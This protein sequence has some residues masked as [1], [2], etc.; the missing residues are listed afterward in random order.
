MAALAST[1][2]SAQG[3]EAPTPGNAALVTL[4]R[5]DLTDGANPRAGLVQA[6]NGNFYGTTRAGGASGYGTV[7]EITPSDELTTL[8][9]FDGTDGG[10]PF[11]GLVQAS[12]GRLYGT[13]Y[14]GGANDGGTIFEITPGGA[15]TTLYSFCHQTGCP[16]GA[17]PAAG[18]VQAKNGDL[19]GTAAAGG[20]TNQGTVF[21]IT[22][23][24]ALTE[25]YSF[26][27]QRDCPDGAKPYAALIQASDGNFYGTTSY[28][29]SSGAGTVFRITPGGALTTLHSFCSQI[30]C[31]DGLYPFAGLIQA[32]D[33]NLYGTTSGEGDDSLHGTVFKITPSGTLTTLYSFAPIMAAR[34]AHTRLPGSSRRVTAISMGPQV[35][36]ERL[37]TARYS[38]SPRTAH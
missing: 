22:P 23:S 6:S 3:P 16:D 10:Q 37:A 25:L 34:T 20:A 8:F 19:Y 38:E 29:G 17:I 13:T 7:F 35:M 27:H 14:V 26:C 18:L 1:P 33:G 4:Q 28:G 2:A 30:G 15:L 24:G 5:F 11:A 12:N 9:N 32:S 21:K 36:A 31:T